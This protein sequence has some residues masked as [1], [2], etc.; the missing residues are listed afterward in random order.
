[1]YVLSLVREQSKINI[2]LSNNTP[3]LFIHLPVSK[4]LN[5]P[6][7]LTIYSSSLQSK[8]HSSP[9]PLHLSSLILKPNQTPYSTQ[10]QPEY[11]Y[12]Y[13]YPYRY[14]LGRTILYYTT[15]IY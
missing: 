10:T 13:P 1:M 12:P 14:P 8:F 7:S 4:T 11:P 5:L 6:P 9:H 2:D 3:Q 15:Y